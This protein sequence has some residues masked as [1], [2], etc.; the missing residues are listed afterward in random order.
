MD[1]DPV[2]RKE[3]QGQHGTNYDAWGHCLLDSNCRPAT[4]LGVRP[5]EYVLPK[6]AQDAFASSNLGFLLTNLNVRRIVFIGGHTEACLGKT[7]G[8]ARQRGFQTLCV[9][10]A[11]FNARESTRAK[12]IE[13]AQYDYVLTTAQFLELAKEA[14]GAV[15]SKDAKNRGTRHPD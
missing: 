14:A 7:A 1:L 4:E 6:T 12:G 15:A 11:T 2:V 10:D 9:E 13:Q 5:G 3:L 8:S